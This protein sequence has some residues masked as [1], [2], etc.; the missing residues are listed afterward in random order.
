MDNIPLVIG[1]RLDKALQLLNNIPI[2]IIET[3]TPFE[4][5]IEERQGNSPIVIRQKTKNDVVKLTITYFASNTL[6]Q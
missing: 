5:K 1:Y 4:D 6:Q 2:D 3:T